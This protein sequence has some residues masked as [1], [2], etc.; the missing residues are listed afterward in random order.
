MITHPNFV[1]IPLPALPPSK[2][3]YS[4]MPKTRKVTR[5]KYS[6][7]LRADLLPSLQQRG[8]I[9]HS[10]VTNPGTWKG[11]IRMPEQLGQW[12]DRAERLAGIDKLEGHFRWMTMK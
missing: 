6:N 1:H 8:L 2:A 4:F 11:V 12:G 7:L 3:A 5:D 9:A 10:V